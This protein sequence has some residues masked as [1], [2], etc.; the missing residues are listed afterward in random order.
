MRYGWIAAALAVGLLLGLVVPRQITGQGLKP[1]VTYEEYE[2]TAVAS[3]ESKRKLEDLPIVIKDIYGS[4]VNR[5]P[6]ALTRR[7]ITPRRFVAFRTQA[8]YGSDMLCVL[9]RAQEESIQEYRK[10]LEGGKILIY[11]RFVFQIG[12]NYVFLVDRFQRGWSPERKTRS[13]VITVTRPGT[14]AKRLYRLAEPGKTY[15]IFS[16]YDNKAIYISY[17]F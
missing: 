13:I 1:D 14:T 5:F 16:P 2:G 9:P 17:Q 6:E 8:G 11:G 10:T 3:L 12:L 4:Q 15:R 7:N